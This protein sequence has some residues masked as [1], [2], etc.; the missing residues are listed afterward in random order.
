[1]TRVRTHPGRVLRAELEARGLSAN[2]LALNIR[3]ICQPRI[4]A[5]LFVFLCLLWP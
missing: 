2:R 3:G 5:I 1:M 4:T